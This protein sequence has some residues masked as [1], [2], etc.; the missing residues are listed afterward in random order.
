M[1]IVGYRGRR[2]ADVEKELD[3]YR[4]PALSRKAYCQFEVH[5]KLLA[6]DIRGTGCFLSRGLGSAPSVSQFKTFFVTSERLSLVTRS[7]ST[8]GWRL[9]SPALQGHHPSQR[10]G[11]GL[12]QIRHYVPTQDRCLLLTF[13]PSSPGAPGCTRDPNVR[14]TTIR[15]VPMAA[16]AAK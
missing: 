9:I 2:R 14:L 8:S 1:V 11:S 15:R 13:L 12:L 5:H 10:E 16:N 3:G 6:D 4:W 7:I